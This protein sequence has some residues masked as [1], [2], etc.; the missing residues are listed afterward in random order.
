MRPHLVM[1]G[2]LLGLGAAAPAG[3]EDVAAAEALFRRGLAAMQAGRYPEACA[4]LAESQRLDP[5][6]GALFTLAECRSSEQKIASAVALYDDYLSEFAALSPTEQARQR[7][8]E[9]IAAE[10]K[11][12]LGPH[13]PRLVLRLPSGVSA[14]VTR[15]DVTLRPPALG[16]PLPVDPGEHQVTTQIGGGGV[17]RQT[18]TI[19]LDEEKVVDLEVMSPREAVPPREEHPSAEPRAAESPP[20]SGGG[21]RPLTFAAL[22]LGAAGL[23][24]GAASGAFVLAQRG[25]VDANCV[26]RV[27][28]AAGLDA[29]SS[30]KTAAGVST[31]GFVAGGLGVVA[32]GILFLTD[33]RGPE[34]SSPV[35]SWRPAFGSVD[36]RGAFVGVRREW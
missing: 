30:A 34:P 33:R 11:R 21:H 32:A 9:K 20:P 26:N 5:R 36:S 12:A 1:L 4:A 23:A 13:V 25:T 31:G 15:D 29:V 14:S 16:I 17:H 19:G 2:V 27:C 35:A 6:P 18:I 28:T 8:R 24:V 3:A 7:G 10:K 22:G